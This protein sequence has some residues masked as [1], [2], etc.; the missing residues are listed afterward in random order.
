MKVI[1]LSREL[2]E[3]MPVYP[4][5]PIFRHT[6]LSVARS[7]GEVT[8]SRVEMGAH[9]GTHVDLPA[10]FVPGGASIE[11]LDASRFVAYGSVID[12]SYKRPGEAITAEDLWRRSELIKRGEAVM[13]YTGFSA[14]YGTE[15]FLYNWPYLDRGAADYL[16]EARVAAVG[17]EGMSVAGYPG[18]QGFPY[19][20]RVSKDDVAY[21]HY[22]L[23]SSGVIV[24]ENVTNLDKV[25]SECGGRALF[26][27]APIKIR[28]GEGGPA[29]VL[30]LC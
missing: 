27:F 22:K 14:K 10:H 24:I 2:Y 16:A 9:T 1:D 25:L 26:I 8:L 11:A 13:I 28:G 6:Y 12:L 23:L 15:E 30:A 3:G 20:P 29:R 17:V 21:V 5:D 7:Y 18:V 4:G 19:P